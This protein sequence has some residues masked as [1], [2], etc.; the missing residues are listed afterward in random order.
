M[1]GKVSTRSSTLR[2]NILDL[3]LR[4]SALFQ[5]PPDL[6]SLPYHDMEVMPGKR[7]T[8]HRLRDLRHPLFTRP[9]CDQ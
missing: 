7:V 8:P 2:K 4:L 3:Q 6:I 5:W 1:S 9:H